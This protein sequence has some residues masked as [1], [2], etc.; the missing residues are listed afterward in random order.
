M[1]R[2]R[3]ETELVLRKSLLEKGGMFLEIGIQKREVVLKY[4]KIRQYP[5]KTKVLADRV[6]RSAVWSDIDLLH[7]LLVQSPSDRN[8]GVTQIDPFGIERGDK[9]DIHQKGLVD[10]EELPGRQFFLKTF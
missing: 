6:A 9:T 10:S 4:R 2:L 3:S 7:Q 1:A 5:D 8:V